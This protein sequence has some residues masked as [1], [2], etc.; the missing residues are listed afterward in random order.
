MYA[1]VLKDDVLKDDVLND[2]VLKDG[3]LEVDVLMV[4]VFKVDDLSWCPEIQGCE[5]PR[6]IRHLNTCCAVF[7]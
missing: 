5:T 6:R 7:T 3:V 1:D 4:G 2:G